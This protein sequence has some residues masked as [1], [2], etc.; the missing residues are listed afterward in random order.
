MTAAA[1]ARDAG[2][3][4]AL[5][6]ED[7]RFDLEQAISKAARTYPFFTSD[8]VWGLLLEQGV[9]ELAH[10]N[11]LG[12]GFLVAARAGIIENTGRVQKSSRTAGRRRA[13]AIWRSRISPHQS[14]DT[15]QDAA[16]LE[17]GGAHGVAAQQQPA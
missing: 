5:E 3:A 16:T 14:V 1:A 11:A 8:Q 17:E 2:A 9:Q 4:L 6:A 10:P 15:C 12:A 13:V 7:H